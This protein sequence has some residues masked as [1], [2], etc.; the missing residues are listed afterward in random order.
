MK[1]SLPIIIIACLALSACNKKGT[2][3]P[4]KTTT[5]T[6]ITIN[7]Q[8]YPTA[9]I[10]T[11]TWTIVDYHD[12]NAMKFPV[13]S[14]NDTAYLYTYTQLRNIT[15]PDGWRLP[16]A[17]DFTVLA[18]FLGGTTDSRGYGTVSGAAAQMLTSTHWPDVAGTNSTKF[19]ANYVGA[20]YSAIPGYNFEGVGYWTSTQDGVEQLDFF[21]KNSN[22]T[23]AWVQ[24][25]AIARDLKSDGF[26][27]RF[28]KSN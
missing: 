19:S 21:I 25:G 1:L 14:L 22:S 2:L 12:A 20:Y 17:T 8:Q 26:C 5:T 16:S 7:G 10:G 6:D 13:S 9:I 3:A 15:P 27:V 18:T 4:V 24:T 11:Q 23:G 28:V